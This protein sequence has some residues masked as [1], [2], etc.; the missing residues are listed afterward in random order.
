MSAVRKCP[1]CKRPTRHPRVKVAEHPGTVPR[2]RDGKC[3]R[4][5]DDVKRGSVGRAMTPRADVMEDATWLLGAGE[6]DPDVIARR[7]GMSLA[8][9]AKSLQRSDRLDLSRSFHRADKNART[10]RLRTAEHKE[11]VNA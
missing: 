11:V 10:A 7:L 5:L 3:F 2:G 9:I 4:C 8:A 1:G 6:V